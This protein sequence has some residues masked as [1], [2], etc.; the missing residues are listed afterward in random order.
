MRTAFRLLRYVIRTEGASPIFVL[1]S[2]RPEELATVT[3]AVTL[4]AD[5]E[6][7]GRS[8]V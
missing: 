8:A 3:E 6:R 5:M 7:C 4:I 2:I 1:F